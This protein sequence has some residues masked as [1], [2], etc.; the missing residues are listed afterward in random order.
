MAEIDRKKKKSIFQTMS[1]R[2]F[3]LL[4]IMLILFLFQTIF[5]IL[6]INGIIPI[7]PT[8]NYSSR[9]DI[10]LTIGLLLFAVC[11]LYLIKIFIDL[12]E[13]KRKYGKGGGYP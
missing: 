6:I 9:W 11:L 3:F 4:L 7:N 5:I 8:K 12:M 2:N 13:Y 10:I 1:F